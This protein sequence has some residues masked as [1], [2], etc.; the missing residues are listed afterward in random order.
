MSMN[1]TCPLLRS[2][3]SP[4]RSKY[5]IPRRASSRARRGARRSISLCTATLLDQLLSPPSLAFARH[6]SP[7]APTV[8]CESVR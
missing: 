5:Q 2:G 8:L 7:A 3:I 1:L 6:I 4:L